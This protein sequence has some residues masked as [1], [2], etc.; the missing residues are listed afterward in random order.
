ML[1][2]NFN[3]G[4]LS[5]NDVAVKDRS[6]QLSVK[7]VKEWAGVCQNKSRLLNLPGAD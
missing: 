2:T 4:W 7:V 3:W 1:F 6:I 5:S